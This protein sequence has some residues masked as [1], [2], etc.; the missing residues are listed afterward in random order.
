MEKLPESLLK[1][2]I[3]ACLLGEKVRYDGAHKRHLYITNVMAEQFRFVPV[4]P[5]VELGM[6]VPRE[7]VDLWGKPD[8]PRMVQQ[9]TGEDWT[10]RMVNYAAKRVRQR[11]L[12]C[13]RGYIFKEDS[14]SCGLE[15]VRLLSSH[16]QIKHKGRGLFAMALTLRFSHL[17]AIEAEQLDDVRLRENFLVCVFAYDRLQKLLKG[18]LNQ[19]RLLQF[20][21][22]E[23]ELLRANNPNHF[24]HLERLMAKAE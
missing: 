23:K 19:S 15:R 22:K 3:S 21:M 24:R 4:C 10:I 18:R 12:S 2:G 6:G 20:H 1:I 17:P 16:G 7:A 11:D 8:A 9:H 14:P 13:L 5:E